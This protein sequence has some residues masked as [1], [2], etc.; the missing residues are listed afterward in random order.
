MMTNQTKGMRKTLSIVSKLAISPHPTIAQDL[1][2]ENI[3]TGK[4]KK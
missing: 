1:P 2:A 3:K 4:P